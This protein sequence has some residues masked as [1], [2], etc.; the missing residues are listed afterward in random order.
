MKANKLK[1]N[2]NPDDYLIAD[3]EAGK[4]YWKA[5]PVEHFPSNR[6]ANSWNSRWENKEA[7]TY[8]D[9][10]GY[11]KG[12]LNNS[13]YLAHR[14]IWR[15][16]TGEWPKEYLDHIDGDPSNNS[17]TNLREV[18]H[19]QNLFNKKPD[20]GLSKYKGVC[21]DEKIKKYKS[22]L[23]IHK[24]ETYVGYF[25][26]EEEAARAYDQAAKKYFGKYA[27]LNFKGE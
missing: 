11:K 21:W 25:N 16:Y 24:K 6:I 23:T 15:M 5:R 13:S 26:T 12:T 8:N 10:R 3:F 4:L 22:K 27:Y 18:T 2:F 17:L 20:K 9:N 7:F 1:E 19:Q 14:V